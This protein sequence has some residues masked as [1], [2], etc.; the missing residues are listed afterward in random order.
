[1]KNFNVDFLNRQADPNDVGAIVQRQGSLLKQV[2]QGFVRVQSLDE[3]AAEIGALQF[4][5][6][7]PSGQLRMIMSAINLLEEFGINA[8]F[9]GFDVN[10]VAQIYLSADDGSL[11]A[12]GG[13][14]AL[15]QDGITIK[16]SVSAPV[17]ANSIKWVDTAENV[18][19]HIY[20]YYAGLVAYGGDFVIAPASGAIE[21]A[22]NSI[23]AQAR[24]ATVAQII[25]KAY[26][27]ASPNSILLNAEIINSNG[28]IDLASGKTYKIN[29]AVVNIAETNANDIFRC[30]TPGGPSLWTGTII[31]APSGTSV[32]VSAPATGTDG[33]LVPVST[34]HLAKMRLYNLT[35]GTN[36]L[37]SNYNTGT[38][39]VTLTATV[40]A[41]WANGDS[42]TIASQTVSG[43]GLS[44]VDIEITS[45]PTNKS[46]V[47]VK[48]IINSATVGD[49]MRIHPF[50]ASHSSSKYDVLY[51]LVTSQNTNGVGL[52]TVTNN[53]FS[54]SWTGTPNT[55]VIREAGYLS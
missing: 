54:L 21:D 16:T 43:S 29:G 44:W 38:N 3:I 4:K 10:G 40:P 34:S 53:V 35:R 7:E 20:S 1:M 45:G 37:I 49:V 31:G 48:L 5:A 51:A 33:V 42:L 23:T 11:K 12:G 30:N 18:I 32:T 36:A 9:A 24:D 2:G 25:L 13:E 17:L 41:E 39:V 8:H 15:N 28:D 19:K 27:S 46:S 26:N 47:F 6:F 50:D 14:V 22:S 52:I 55:I